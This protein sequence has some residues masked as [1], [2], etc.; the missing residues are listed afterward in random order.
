MKGIAEGAGVTLTDIILLNARYDL[1]RI[2]TGSGSLNL[3]DECTSTAA[4]V[5]E[6]LTYDEESPSVYIAQNWDIS[7]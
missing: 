1:S 6:S 4:Y 3:V 7:F 2:Q 5:Y